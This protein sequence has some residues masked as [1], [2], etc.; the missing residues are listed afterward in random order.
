MTSG[1]VLCYSGGPHYQGIS[2]ESLTAI[3]HSIEKIHPSLKIERAAGSIF[4]S[5]LTQQETPFLVVFP[6]G[7]CSTWDTTLNKESIRSI[8]KF[9][10]KGGSALM[11]CAG[12]YF[13]AKRSLFH[14]SE[15]IIEKERTLKF[16]AGTV[17]GPFLSPPT[18][19]NGPVK[20]L[21]TKIRWQD[22]SEGSVYIYGGGQ[23]HPEDDA[24]NYEVLARYCS[25]E[26]IAIVKCNVDKGTVIL[27]S[28]HLEFDEIPEGVISQ[29]TDANTEVN[30]ALRESKGFRHECLTQI[31]NK[32][33]INEKLITSTVTD[34]A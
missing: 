23:F 34:Y 22:G 7:Q 28:V 15:G 11:V 24:T 6:G 10:K 32:L 8:R 25:D 16:F 9:I 17:E 26:S 19:P 5:R 4:A 27:S 3:E 33:K 1:L 29:F 12:A 21:I 13:A 31:F 2:Y 14:L 30:T 18:I 20:N